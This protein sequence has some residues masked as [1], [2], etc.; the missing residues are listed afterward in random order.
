MYSQLQG[1]TVGPPG[2]DNE[3]DE[4]SSDDV[5][6]EA[7]APIG[8]PASTADIGASG[9]VAPA[10]A[11]LA[12]ETAPPVAS[13]PTPVSSLLAEIA[14]AMQVA[15]DQER[16]RIEA[17][18]GEEE[19]AQ[20]EKI[21]VRAAFE[22]DELE[23]YAEEDVR[24]VNAWREDQIQRVR[25]DAD[26]QIADRRRRLEQSL[27]H[28]GSL[29]QTEIESVQVAV[30]G[31]RESL[32]AFFGRLSQER[33]PSVI[34]RLAG[35][36]PD[37]PDLQEVRADARSGAMKE[38]QQRSAADSAEPTAESLTAGE[39]SA[40]LGKEPVGVMEPGVM[41]PGVMEPGVMEHS[42]G[43]GA[44]DAAVPSAHFAGPPSWIRTPPEIVSTV[45][46]PETIPSEENV[47][48]RLIRSLTNRTSQTD[49]P[50]DD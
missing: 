47:A 12:E 3:H 34:A 28:H 49:S 5:E 13:R 35:Q 19:T 39:D 6:G 30:R 43:F 17:S 15:A 29:I 25:Q 14:R 31:Y 22:S 16:E 23:K 50:E 21:H 32:G 11:P 9:E 46:P 36:L 48:V 1:G 10:E 44:T 27:T 18:M 26:R 42:A 40:E 4:P 41:E 37:P 8:P 45:S 20:I 24:Q 2:D 7:A 33:D 38:I